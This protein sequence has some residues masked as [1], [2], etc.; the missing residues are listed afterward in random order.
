MDTELLIKTIQLMLAPAVMISACGLLL[1]GINGKNTAISNRLRLLNDE[2]RRYFAKIRDG[3]E[4]E[5]FESSRFYSIQKQI[6]VSLY[7]MKLVRNVIL[8]YVLGLFMF[9]FTSLLIGIEIFVQIFITKYLI[10]A[11][12]SSG[13]LL[14]AI[15]L[16]FA[17]QDTLKG[18]KILEVETKADD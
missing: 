15:G 5:Y 12:F 18:Y 1:L 14:I 2:K 17:L 4:L 3:K 9:I 10:L 8:C 16:G 6:K 13:M 7:R 11:A